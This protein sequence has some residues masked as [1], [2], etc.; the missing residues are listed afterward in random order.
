MTATLDTSYLSI[1]LNAKKKT[2]VSSR[3]LIVLIKNVKISMINLYKQLVY[4]YMF[5]IK[6]SIISIATSNDLQN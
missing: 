3:T 5:T 6:E 2:Y 1:Q 4:W